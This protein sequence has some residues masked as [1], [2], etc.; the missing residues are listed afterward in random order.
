MRR[1]G[2][3]SSG[4]RFGGRSTIGHGVAERFGGAREPRYALRQPRG[5]LSAGEARARGRGCAVVA[6]HGAVPLIGTPTASSGCP[7]CPMA[8]GAVTAARARRTPPVAIAAPRFGRAGRTH[9]D[10]RGDRCGERGGEQAHDRAG[11]GAGSACK[12]PCTPHR[13]PSSDD[14]L[15]LRA[16]AAR[17]GPLLVGAIATKQGERRRYARPPAHADRRICKSS[18]AGWNGERTRPDVCLFRI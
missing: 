12:S 2:A 7:P 18:D 6:R 5:D 14:C 4:S 3:R 1:R 10:R 16:R 17:T 15:G 13:C 9:E 8:T 11:A